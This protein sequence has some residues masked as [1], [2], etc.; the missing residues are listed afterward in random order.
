MSKHQFDRAAPQQQQDSEPLRE[1]ATSTPDASYAG[2]ALMQ[3]Q[4]THGNRHV[5]GVVKAARHVA[6]PAPIIQTKLVLGA[7]SDR[8]EREADRVAQQVVGQSPG[9]DQ[10]VP[11]DA[12]SSRV[13]RAPDI[14][15]MHGAEGGAVD[16]G[17]Q[18][19]IQSARGGGQPL[20][21]GVRAHMEQALGADFGEVRLHT[22]AQADA[23]NQSLQARA[24]T[25]GQDI[26]FRRGGFEPGSQNGQALLAHELAHVIQQD[27]SASPLIQRKLVSIN[28]ST[29]HFKD[30]KTGIEAIR[31]GTD[32]N[33]Y[34]GVHDGQDYIIETVPAVRPPLSC[35]PP[36]LLLSSRMH[37][38]PGPLLALPP[39]RL[40]HKRLHKQFPKQLHKQQRLLPLLK[41][42]LQKAPQNSSFNQ[43]HPSLIIGPRRGVKRNTRSR[44]QLAG[45]TDK[46]RQAGRMQ[47]RLAV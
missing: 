23:L 27:G 26:F 2:H 45:P 4:R 7:A 44:R 33:V 34:V 36:I 24:F 22:D 39:Y 46:A 6:N 14:Q 12:R 21:D 41:L 15:R 31:I 17:V 28:N 43:H 20:P 35:K 1:G 3:L 29:D 42:L 8:Y 25:N 47:A 18:Q 9:L 40:R 30:D 13:M 38:S 37:R 5:Q 16:M 11:Q 10:P 19:A 32:P